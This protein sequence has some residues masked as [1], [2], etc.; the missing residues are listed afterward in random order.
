MNNNDYRIY[1]KHKVNIRHLKFL[2][3][4]ASMTIS[5]FLETEKPVLAHADVS[6]IEDN[7]LSVKCTP[8]GEYCLGQNFQLSVEAEGDGL[9]YQWEFLRPGKTAWE[10]WRASGYDT[11]T[12]T[13]K[14][15]ASYDGF[16]L[17]CAIKDQYGNVIRSKAQTLKLYKTELK[18]VEDTKGSGDGEYRLGESFQYSVKAEGDGLTYQWEFLRPGNTSWEN[19][20]ASGYNTKTTGDNMRASYDGFQLRCAIKDQYGRMITS[21]A[22][23]IVADKSISILL[24][25]TC[26]NDGNLKLGDCFKCSVEAEGDGLAYQWEF[27]RPGKTTWEN[28]RSSGYNTQTTTDKMLVSYDG[29]RIRCSIT[30]T[31]GVCI[32]SRELLLQLQYTTPNIMMSNYAKGE[33]STSKSETPYV[34]VAL[35]KN[36]S[37]IKLI[38]NGNSVQGNFDF[39]YDIREVGQYQIAVK[40]SNNPEE[41]DFSSGS[42]AYSDLY[43][44]DRPKY[45]ITLNSNG[46]IEPSAS[47]LLIGD[48]G[49]YI[50]DYLSECTPYLTGYI[51]T[52]W[53]KDNSIDRPLN[54]SD[55]LDKDIELVAG[56]KA[57]EEDETPIQ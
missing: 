37:I 7:T 2:V 21:S 26:T 1:R 8:E 20:R 40:A 33:Y 54:S 6:K 19:W 39:Y 51:F 56:W 23:T 9:T 29:F 5:L 27:L 42:I 14:M 25:T 50:S 46:G 13:D 11:Q 15:L 34:S 22:I 35:L 49:S 48:E 53:Y 31:F 3:I 10:N 16:Q 36:G 12:T 17:R 44:L 24:D 32:K 43:T 57:I 4:V 18:L 45:L 30:N 41:N 55:I 52:G 38:H 47:N 28:W